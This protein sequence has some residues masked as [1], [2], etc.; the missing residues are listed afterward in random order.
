MISLSVCMIVKNEQEVIA[1]CLE[2]IKDIADE[3]IIVDTGS[4]DKTKQIANNYTNKIYDFKW[5]NDFSKARNFSFAKA[6]KDY[7]MWLD[8]DDIIKEKDRLKLKNLKKTIDNNVDFLMLKYD[9]SFDENDNP[10]FSYYRERI[11]KRNKNI[12]WIGKIHE[13]IPLSGI[14]KYYDI[15]ISHKKIKQ[16]DPKRNLNIFND[17]IKNG[18]TFNSREL[19]YYA[20]ELYYNEKVN[21][22]IKIFNKFLDSKDGFIENKISACLDLYNIYM[23]LNDEKKALNSLLRSFEY[24]IP[25]A[26]ICSNLGNYFLNKNNI[27]TAI[28]WYEEALKKEVDLKSGGFCILDMYNFIPYI[29]LCVCYDRLGD[30]EKAKYYNELAGTIKP[31]DKSYLYNKKYFKMN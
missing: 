19:F 9:V 22:S 31:Y 5:C 27:K 28:Y 16:N 15:A 12:K 14:V 1:R 24:D 18:D 11:I 17:M 3:I 20:R 23:N 21:E 26:E 29:N 7:I 10:T 25:R 4:Y 13:V 6:T 30:K 8:A 2:C